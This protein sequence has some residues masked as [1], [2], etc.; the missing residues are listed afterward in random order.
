MNVLVVDIGG[1]TVKIAAMDQGERRK[2]AS[3]PTM[4]AHQM[5]AG[6]THLARDWK[7]D[8]VSIGYPGV[9][10]HNQPVTEPC[11][12]GATAST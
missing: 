7:Y 10:K 4:T 5:I 8:R 11:W 12:A 6:V 9:V 3:G 1:T 2:F